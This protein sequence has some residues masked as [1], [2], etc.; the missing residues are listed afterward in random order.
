MG[1]CVAPRS[2]AAGIIIGG[3]HAAPRGCAHAHP[4]PRRTPPA[5]HFATDVIDVHT[6]AVRGR[7]ALGRGRRAYSPASLGG[8]AGEAG[9]R[10]A[11]GL[12]IDRNFEGIFEG[13]ALFS[14]ACW[15]HDSGRLRNS[16]RLS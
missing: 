6:V 15:M 3:L 5:L 16:A 11:E 10:G 12:G 7:Q 8:G 13:K 9:A 2:G 14:G 1:I 4:A